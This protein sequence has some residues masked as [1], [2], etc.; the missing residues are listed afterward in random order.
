MS[1]DN[2]ATRWW[3]QEYSKMLSEDQAKAGSS[4]G[5]LITDDWPKPKLS[6]IMRC[7]Y[8]AKEQPEIWNLAQ[9]QAKIPLNEWDNEDNRMSNLIGPFE[10]WFIYEN[11]LQDHYPFAFSA[12]SLFF[13]EWLQPDFDGNEVEVA[14]QILRPRVYIDDLPEDAG[15]FK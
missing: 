7:A 13:R 12:I 11:G 4:A 8:L 1:A 3:E 9:E 2:K 15:D 6:D 5:K 14:R 10:K